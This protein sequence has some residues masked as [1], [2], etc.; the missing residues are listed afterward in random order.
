MENAAKKIL[1]HL[2]TREEEKISAKNAFKKYKE[3]WKLIFDSNMTYNNRM[4]YGFLSIRENTMQIKHDGDGLVGIP[5]T[6]TFKFRR[7]NDDDFIEDDGIETVTINGDE[8]IVIIPTE[9]QH[10]YRIYDD[11][12]K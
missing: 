11:D 5:N 1:R 2:P 3:S 12:D 7:S 10:I 9:I 4:Y 8:Y 6:Y